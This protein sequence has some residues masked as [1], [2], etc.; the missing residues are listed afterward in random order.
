[1]TETFLRMA[2]SATQTVRSL[3]RRTVGATGRLPGLLDRSMFSCS[4]PTLSHALSA[5][6]S[7]YLQ[8]IDERSRTSRAARGMEGRGSKLCT[9]NDRIAFTTALVKG[10]HWRVVDMVRTLGSRLRDLAIC[11]SRKVLFL[12]IETPNRAKEC[13]GSL[14]RAVGMRVMELRGGGRTFRRC[15][16]GFWMQ[17]S[18]FSR[19]KLAE[20][21]CYDTTARQLFFG[22]SVFPKK[23][24]V[25]DCPGS[26]TSGEELVKS[27]VRQPLR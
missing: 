5:S 6:S 25:R 9:H 7:G 11:V 18:G 1:M 20:K 12:V 23:S 22:E 21:R 24:R 19:S 17:L 15:W 3:V 8:P 4:S 14:L 26:S 13:L 27:S 2:S 10:G 16:L